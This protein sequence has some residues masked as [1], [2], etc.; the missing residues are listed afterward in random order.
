M[1]Y[2]LCPTL[3]I[4]L[5]FTN[6]T[7]IA[8][9]VCLVYRQYIN[10]SVFQLICYNRYAYGTKIIIENRR[11]HRRYNQ[12]LV[13]IQFEPRHKKKQDSCLC[14]NKGADQHRSNCDADQRLCFR[15]TDSTVP[16]H[17]KSGIPMF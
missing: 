14:E 15:Y 2:Y 16:L 5:R 9:S 1:V 6:D 11:N 4:V 13:I 10:C 3:N 17:F 12:F 7:L 8:K